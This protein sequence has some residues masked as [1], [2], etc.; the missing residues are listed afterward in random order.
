MTT[1]ISVKDRLP[2]NDGDD[3]LLREPIYGFEKP[4]HIYH[5]GIFETYDHGSCWAIGHGDHYHY[6][7]G[8]DFDR[9]TH[10]AKIEPPEVTE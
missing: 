6:W 4:Y 1:W 8:A 9:I 2:G 7:F 3:L 5:V 10:W